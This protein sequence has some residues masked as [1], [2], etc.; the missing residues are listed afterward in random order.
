MKILVLGLGNDL[1]AD[2]AAGIFAARRVR[3]A[4]ESGGLPRTSE[5]F[6]V[7]VLECSV[8]GVALLDVF[9][10]YDRAIV[11]DSVLTGKFPPGTVQELD[12]ARLGAVLAPSAHYSGLPEILAIARELAVP[13]PREIE[14]LALE[15]ADPH[16]IGGDISEPVRSALP[17]LAERVLGRLRAW[18]EEA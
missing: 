12:P 13:F 3:E 16:T 15:V 10:G 5:D 11:I 8:S 4:I 1:I 7:D 17:A 9:A 18:A 14:I 6:R 2:D